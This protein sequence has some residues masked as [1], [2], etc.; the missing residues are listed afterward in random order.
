MKTTFAICKIEEQ[1][2]WTISKWIVQKGSVIFFLISV[3]DSRDER[4]AIQNRL[5][6]VIISFFIP[7]RFFMFWGDYISLI[8]A[9]MFILGL[10][11]LADFAHTWCKMCLQN[12]EAT[13]L[14]LWQCILIGSTAITY[15]ASI[16]LTGH[17]LHSGLARAGMVATYC[18]YLVVSAVLNYTHRSCNPLNNASGAKTTTVVLGAVFTFLEITYSTSR[19]TMQSCVLVGKMGVV[20]TQPGCMESP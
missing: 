7:N 17:N 13:D 9:T 16:T 12:W 11:L 14:T 20:S 19:A 15:I 6:L 1:S 3:N 2:Y 8:D 4:A 5:L 18:T 10:I